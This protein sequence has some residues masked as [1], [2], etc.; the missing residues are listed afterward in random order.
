MG[1]QL[2]GILN[3]AR[4]ELSYRNMLMKAGRKAPVPRSPILRSIAGLP[5][6]VSPTDGAAVRELA[7]AADDES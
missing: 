2:K 1:Q 3:V 7:G 4:L 6:A 5:E